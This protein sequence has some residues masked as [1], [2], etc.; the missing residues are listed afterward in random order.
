MERGGI[1]L[2]SPAIVGSPIGPKQSWPSLRRPAS[3]SAL[4]P[5][6]TLDNTGI[7]SLAKKIACQTPSCCAICRVPCCSIRTSP[8]VSDTTLARAAE[9]AVG[10]VTPE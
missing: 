1:T 2:T 9:M 5:G 3:K 6:T 8:T 10:V 4:Y 7:F